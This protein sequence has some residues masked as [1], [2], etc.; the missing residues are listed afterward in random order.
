MKTLIYYQAVVEEVRRPDLDFRVEA[1]AGQA[2]SIVSA[3]PTLRG[4]GIV[5]KFQVGDSV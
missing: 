1:P 3:L 2:L 5:L 4:A